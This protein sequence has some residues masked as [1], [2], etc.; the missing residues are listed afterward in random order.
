M[1]A[2]API[3]PHLL[4]PEGLGGEI[5]NVINGLNHQVAGQPT[6]NPRWYAFTDIWL[7]PVHGKDTNLGNAESV[8]V[9]TVQEVVRRY[10]SRRPQLV[11]GQNLTLHVMGSQGLNVDIFAFDPLP[12]GGGLYAIVGVPT[13]VATFNLGTVTAKNRAAAQVLEAAG[14]THAGLAQGQLVI[15]NVSGAHAL[16]ENLTGSTAKLSQPVT[17]LAYPADASTFP[18]VTEDDSWATGQSVS[19]YS[20]PAVNMNG[21]DARGGQAASSSGISTC[22]VQYLTLLDASGEAGNSTFQ[23]S[24]TGVSTIFVDCVIQPYTVTGHGPEGASSTIFIGC[25]FEGG[26]QLAAAVQ[27]AGYS[28]LYGTSVSGAQGAVD[29]DAIC[30]PQCTVFGQDAAII[31]TI[32]VDTGNL[33]INACEAWLDSDVFGLIGPCVYGP[34][35]IQVVR[36]GRLFLIGGDAGGGTW[37][38]TVKCTGGITMEGLSTGTKYVAGTPGVF[39]DGIALTAANLDT[40]GGLQNPVTGARIANCPG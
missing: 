23:P 2:F 34:G 35:A 30:R 40:Y 22:W 27:L 19:V 25:G 10:G 32:F 33:I 21:L 37:A 36:G 12:S 29:L 9:K 24:T 4:E 14:F 15:N 16:I 39:T 17:P 5:Q 8:P 31:G 1:D 26:V 13:L 38:G 6:Y 7:D 28:H 18:S 20:L 3:K 11:T